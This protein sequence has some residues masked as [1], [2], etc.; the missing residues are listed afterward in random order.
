[1]L[2]LSLLFLLFLVLAASFF[3]FTIVTKKLALENLRNGDALVGL[4]KSSF[5]LAL[6]YLYQSFCAQLLTL[7]HVVV[8][9]VVDVHQTS[10]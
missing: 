8:L 7:F 2:P 1:M 9:Q 6:I 3:V 4:F 10:F 5:C